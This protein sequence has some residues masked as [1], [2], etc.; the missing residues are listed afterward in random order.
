[1]ATIE[2]VALFARPPCG[3]LDRWE[4]RSRG[5]SAATVPPAPSARHSPRPIPSPTASQQVLHRG[6][7]PGQPD[8]DIERALR[9]AR[10][11]VDAA[12][13]NHRRRS[14]AGSLVELSPD[15][16]AVRGAL[17]R[18]TAAAHTGVICILPAEHGAAVATLDEVGRVAVTGIA[19]RVLCAPA[20]LY[21]AAG[22]RVLDRAQACGIE[23][24]V[25]R[26]PLPELVLVDEWV[27][28]VRARV[29]TAG[30]QTLVA[31]TPAIL[32]TLRALFTAAWDHARP[33]AEHRRLGDLPHDGLSRQILGFLCAGYKD[34]AAARRLQ[35][36]VR[37]YRRYVAELMRDM[38]AASRFQ[39]GVRA[40]ELGLLS[41]PGGDP[42]GHPGQPAIP[43][44]AGPR[45]KTRQ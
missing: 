19:A 42:C 24:R 2:N 41:R 10:A 12:K 5:S 20:A 32:H 9:H 7:A 36:S 18:M 31:R 11:L 30:P 44:S 45:W 14:T 37:T 8:D 16:E 22:R 23:V 27:A 13:S 6:V 38:G 17:R 15:D 40:A 3:R 21:T 25:T 29:D 35:L 33:A 39:A 1:M 4:S 43:P 26:S 28:L 34:D